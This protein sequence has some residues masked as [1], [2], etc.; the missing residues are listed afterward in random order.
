MGVSP[1]FVRFDY[2]MSRQ[3][4][5]PWTE[6]PTRTECTRR[7]MIKRRRE[8]PHVGT[9]LAP[10]LERRGRNTRKAE[11][12]A[13]GRKRAIAEGYTPP[14]SAGPHPQMTSHETVCLLNA[15]PQD[16][17]VS[18][19]VF[20]ADQSPVGPY[21]LVVPAKRTRHV[22]LNDLSIPRRSPSVG[23]SPTSLSPMCR[24][25]CNTPDS[26]LVRRKTLYSVRSHLREPSI[27][28]AN[29]RSATPASSEERTRPD[30]GSNRFSRAWP[31][32]H[33]PAKRRMTRRFSC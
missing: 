21:R 30:D 16:A 28:V 13:I 23:I 4:V 25:S 3:F 17:H 22:W 24:L 20:Y 7:I 27:A 10:L 9:L 33:W 15:G 12:E 14:S 19:R 32:P 6:G 18:I 8:S 11:L 29:E 31:Q 1:A 2:T 26:T 5:W